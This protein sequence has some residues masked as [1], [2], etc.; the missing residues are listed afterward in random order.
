M[1]LFEESALDCRIGRLPGR[2]YSGI[3]T[4]VDFCAHSHRDTT[5]MV[6]GCTAIVTLTRPENRNCR[7]PEEEQFHVL[8]MYRPDAGEAD[9]AAA[10]AAG[11]LTVLDRFSKRVV[12]GE[13]GTPCKRRGA[14]RKTGP[15]PP[16]DEGFSPLKQK[17]AGD[18]SQSE[19]I[20]NGGGA[21]GFTFPEYLGFGSYPWFA[22]PANGIADGGGGQE[23]NIGGEEEHCSENA[24]SQRLQNFQIYESD[25]AE[26]F[27]SENFFFLF[28]IHY[29]S[30][31][32]F[33]AKAN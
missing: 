2:P 4:V 26:A 25:C 12:I 27:R 3:T 24:A 1:C 23:V 14:K 9:M 18:G 21:G 15:Q 13:K 11:G 10:Q 8:P 16:A 33:V 22:A 5:N 6:G 7:E 32:F 31:D 28:L 17:Y 30:L 29:S 19:G 20:A